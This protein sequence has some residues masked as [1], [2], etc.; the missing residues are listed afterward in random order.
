MAELRRAVELGRTLRGR[1]GLRVRQP[2]ARL[3]L[4]MPGGG[5]GAGLGAAARDELLALLAE[6]LNVHDIELISDDSELVERR[7]KPLLPVIGQR[8]REAI[9]AIMAA[10]R[11]NDGDATT[12]TAASSSAASGWPRTRSRSWPRRGPAPPSP[13]TRAS[14]SSSTRP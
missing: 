11:A 13:T 2:L 12:P 4:A 14:S 1:A 10:A 8:Y 6:E 3:W 9:P 5:L 7:V